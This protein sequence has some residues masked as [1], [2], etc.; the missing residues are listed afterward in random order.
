MKKSELK[1]I[2]RECLK[3]ALFE[4]AK[5]QLSEAR[6]V[7][8]FGLKHGELEQYA[9]RK[10]QNDAEL[11]PRIDYYPRYIPKTTIKHLNRNDDPLPDPAHG[12]QIEKLALDDLG[13]IKVDGVSL[14]ELYDWEIQTSNINPHGWG[15]PHWRYYVVGMRKQ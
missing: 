14:T 13:T 12:K 10:L 3:E 15:V 4:S 5:Q 2:I 1:Q 11:P 8:Y 9:L 6:R 7:A